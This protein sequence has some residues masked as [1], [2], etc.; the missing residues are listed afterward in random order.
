MDVVMAT[1]L[2]ALTSPAN[3]SLT[4]LTFQQNYPKFSECTQALRTIGSDVLH[5]KQILSSRRALNFLSAGQTLL[6]FQNESS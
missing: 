3:A 5:P 2:L 6:V 4:H 1:A